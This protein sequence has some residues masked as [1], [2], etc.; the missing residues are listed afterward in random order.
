[1]I[2]IWPALTGVLAAFVLAGCLNQRDYLLAPD[3]AGMVITAGGAPVAGALVSYPA[4]D[5]PETVRTGP[6]GAFTL[7]A[8][9]G[10]RRRLLAPGGVHADST[11]VRA[12]APGMEDGWAAAIF[13]NGL[14]RASAEMEVLVIMLDEAAPDPDLSALTQGCLE[15]PEQRHALALT[16]WAG[17]LDPAAPPE[18]LTAERARV[19]YE[20]LNVMLPSGA[21]MQCPDPS[22]LH[23]HLSQGR[24]AL[25]GIGHDR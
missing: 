5:D 18:W 11:L 8:R 23:A 17:A 19:L 9:M 14:G 13:I 4:L 16:R 1:M 22:A 7:E 21:V 2:R 10:E 6:D 15:R 12:R 25:S 20:N 3:S 24:Q